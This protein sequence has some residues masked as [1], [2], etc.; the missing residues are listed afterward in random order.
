V[1]FNGGTAKAPALRERILEQLNHWASEL[2]K[3]S[4]KVLA[5]A[6]YDFAV[7]RGAVNY[8]M[9]RNGKSIRIKSGTSR[10]FYIGVE[11]AAPAVPGLEPPLR[12]V[13]VATY[14]MEEGTELQ[15]D[16]QE[17]ALVV[18]EPATFRFFSHATP[19]LAD[20]STPSIGSTVKQWKQELTELHPIEV[21][22]DS[23]DGDGK[24]IRVKIRSRVTELGVLEVWCTA[25][26]GRKWKL[27]FD[28]RK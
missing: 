11:D 26:D 8:G 24:T 12:A 13:C 4:V 10:S 9:A 22:L 25:A 6:D 23:A 1:L 18:G 17:F 15:L 28:I 20:G 7:S 19:K 14:G 21:R 27:E 16:I 5:D 3:P 2:K